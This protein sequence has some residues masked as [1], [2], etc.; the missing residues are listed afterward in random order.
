MD[1][2]IMIHFPVPVNWCD[3]CD[4]INVSCMVQ[5]RKKPTFL[6]FQSAVSTLSILSYGI[7]NFK[8]KNPTYPHKYHASTK[9]A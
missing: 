1:P 2:Q 6:P 7:Q 4:V 3:E 8:Q 9:I 5:S